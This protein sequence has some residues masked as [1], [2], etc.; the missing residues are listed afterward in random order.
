MFKRVWMGYDSLPERTPGTKIIQAWDTAAKDGAQ[1]DWS[2]CTI[3]MVVD[4]CYYLID[5]TR[6]RFEY[7]RLRLPASCLAQKKRVMPTRCRMASRGS[8]RNWVEWRSS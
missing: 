6:G 7:P 4:N 3:W 2:V 5:L 1:N 8:R